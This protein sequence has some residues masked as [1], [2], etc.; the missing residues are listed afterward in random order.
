MFWGIISK[1]LSLYS[2]KKNYSTII[3]PDIIKY[4]KNK[5]LKI[6]SYNIDG[7]FLHY[8]YL[9]YIKIA[10]YIRYLFTEK[11]IDIICLQEVWEKSIYDLIINNLTDLNLF[12]AQ[13]P[14]KIKFNIG[15]H[16]GLLVISKYQIINNVFEYFESLYLTCNMT[17]KGYQNVTIKINDTHI[18]IINTHLQSSFKYF[19]L[20]FQ[21]NS[22]KQLN[23][24]TDYIDSNNLENCLILGDLN[25]DTDFVD[26][27]LKTNER[28][29]I[30][31]YHKNNITFLNDDEQ[32][33]YFLFYKESFNDKKIKFNIC[34]NI[35]Y[36]DHLPIFL[37]IKGF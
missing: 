2:N 37:N 12:Y 32:L 15:E 24:I 18:N 34:N 35:Y 30:P 9:N 28:L 8:N 17:K 19:N 4:H 14:T 25:L 29:T 27:Y 1:I 22:L 21:G 11:N 6:V 13:P 36:S 10:K 3:S 16:T 33:D 31:Y 20:Y 7:F 23:I 5:D 26:E